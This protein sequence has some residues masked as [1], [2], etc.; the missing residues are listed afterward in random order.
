MYLQH[1]DLAM[2]HAQQRV[3]SLLEETEHDRL[4]SRARAASAARRQRRRLSLTARA[5][6][7]QPVPGHA[8][9][10]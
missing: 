2:Q 4:A 5:Q 7:R 8:G 10:R 9:A 6:P 3:A 1:P